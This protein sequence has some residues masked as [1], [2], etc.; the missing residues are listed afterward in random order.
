MFGSCP[1]CCP[2]VALV[3]TFRRNYFLRI[4]VL[5]KQT[6]FSSLTLFNPLIQ[7]LLL[8]NYEG[9]SGYTQGSSYEVSD[10]RSQ[11]ACYCEKKPLET[12]RFLKSK[13]TFSLYLQVLAPYH[14]GYPSSDRIILLHSTPPSPMPPCHTLHVPQELYTNIM[15]SPVTYKCTCLTPCL[16]INLALYPSGRI[17]I[18]LLTCPPLW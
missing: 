17:L 11:V 3:T 1:W 12:Y 5:S 2:P 14:N 7:R 9:K 4:S 8:V 18:Y 15:S 13:G 6:P 10:P 16:A